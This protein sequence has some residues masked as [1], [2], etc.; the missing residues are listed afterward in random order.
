[1]PIHHQ[2][3]VL[4]ALLAFSISSTAAAQTAEPSE[5][6]APADASTSSLPVELDPDR[7]GTI[8][9]EEFKALRRARAFE[10][11]ADGDG[12]LSLDE[13]RVL[14]PSQ[15]PK[16]MHSRIFRRIDQ[17]GS[18]AIDDI[19]FDA[20]PVRAFDQADADGDGELVGAEIDALR[21]DAD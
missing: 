10:N 17:D 2:P 19:E 5:N 1:M 8:S 18:G 15:V 12:A 21:T 20:T 7:S 14:L 13:F 16:M 11:D 6:A 4:A 3:R 9:V